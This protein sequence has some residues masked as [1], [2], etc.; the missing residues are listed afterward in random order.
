MD[1]L[2]D[3]PNGRR[4]LWLISAIVAAGGVAAGYG[5]LKS[6]TAHNAAEILVIEESLKQKADLQTAL[7]MEQ[8]LLAQL[9]EV[10]ARLG[11]L[12]ARGR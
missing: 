11:R 3:T 5:S 6:D 4:W 2:K 7:Q 9:V 8:V 12:E 1:A 10:N